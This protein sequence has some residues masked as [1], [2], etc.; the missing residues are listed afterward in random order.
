VRADVAVLPDL[1][2]EEQV[3]LIKLSSDNY[4]KLIFTESNWQTVYVS[5]LSTQKCPTTFLTTY[6]CESGFSAPVALKFK[7]RNKRDV[8]LEDLKLELPWLQ[9]D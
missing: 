9:P 3:R 7:H 8:Q 5:I 2:S 1:T 4:L 6:V